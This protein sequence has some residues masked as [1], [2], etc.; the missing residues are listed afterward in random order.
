M[1]LFCSFIEKNFTLVNHYVGQYAF[2]IK[3]I[4][5]LKRINEE[6]SNNYINNIN[7]QYSSTPPIK[8]TYDYAKNNPNEDVLFNQWDYNAQQLEVH[9]KV[10][11]CWYIDVRKPHRAINGGT[12]MRTHLVVDIESNN[13]VRKLI[14]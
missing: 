10:G 2:G 4:K 14:C 8:A 1:F 5:S 11:E 12:D 7:I 3:K 6:F 9:M 13:D